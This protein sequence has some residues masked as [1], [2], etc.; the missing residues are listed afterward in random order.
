M[1]PAVIAAAPPWTGI[2]GCNTSTHLLQTDDEG[3]CIHFLDICIEHLRWLRWTPSN[4]KLIKTFCS[5]TPLFPLSL[6]MSKPANLTLQCISIIAFLHIAGQHIT[7]FCNS[8]L[9]PPVVTFTVFCC[10]MVC[11]N[12]CGRGSVLIHHSKAVPESITRRSFQGKITTKAGNCNQH[13]IEPKGP[14]APLIAE[15]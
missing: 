3:I 12:W 7:P 8:S 6:Q 5:Q 2:N 15:P 14:L 13:V 1:E 11:W 10:R 9:A 4:N